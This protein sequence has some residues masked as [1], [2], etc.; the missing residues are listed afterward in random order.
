MDK[1]SNE[2][3]FHDFKEK[4]GGIFSFLNIRDLIN[5]KRSCKINRYIVNYTLKVN[6][7]DFF[8]FNIMKKYFLL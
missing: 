2:I 5:F 8:M 1:L 4:S 6:I 3:F 7:I